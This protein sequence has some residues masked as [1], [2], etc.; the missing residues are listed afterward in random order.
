MVLT[1]SGAE[2]PL[3]ECRVCADGSYELAEECVECA[4]GLWCHNEDA[5]RCE[6]GMYRRGGQYFMD[7]AGNLH[8]IGDCIRIYGNQSAHVDDPELVQW[9]SGQWAHRE[10]SEELDGRWYNATS[11]GECSCCETRH[12]RNDLYLDPNGDRICE[13]CYEEACSCCDRCGATCFTENLEYSEDSDD[14]LC[15]DCVRRSNRLIK[16]YS[17]KSANRKPPEYQGKDKYGIELEAEHK[18]NAEEGAEYVA[19]FLDKNYVTFKRDGSLG[20]NG[21]EIVTRPDGMEVHK[22][23]FK[24]LFDDG[25]GK[26]LSSWSNG[27]CGMHVHINRAALSPLQ[28]GKL[29][30]FLNEP[31]NVG[32][33]S[34]VA[35]RKPGRWCHAYKKKITDIHQSGERYVALNI[36]SKTAEVRIF[37]GTLSQAGF[38][39]NLEF[40]QALVEFCAPANRGITE[41]VSAKEFCKWL[42]RKQYPTLHKF[43]VERG[44]I[45]W[46]HK[47]KAG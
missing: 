27:R 37:R 35:G 3:S 36:T 9:E 2:H 15:E 17:D 30:C 33:I 26:H 8:A 5:V 29:L 25:P 24:A 18:R 39:K 43:L 22:R 14:N 13:G 1:A 28:L 10:D 41:A 12:L 46:N 40:V 34:R 38:F 31:T 11:V 42:P 6:D 44:F 19:Q 32:M 20:A 16:D 21:F 4:D 23:K 47:R 7:Y 45:V